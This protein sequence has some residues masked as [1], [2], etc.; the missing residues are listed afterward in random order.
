MAWPIRSLAEASSRI[1]GAFRQYMPGTDAALKNNTI[2]I[3]GKVLTVMVHEFEL[4]L[5]FLAKQLFLSTATGQWLVLHCRDIGIYRKPASAASG[6]AIG[7]AAPSTTYPA[8]VRLLSGNVS[9][10]STAAATSTSGGVLSLSVLSE[11]KGA[12]SNREEGGLLD[13]ADPILWPDLGT[14]W[15]VGAAGLGGGAD[16]EQDES[17][18]ERG[19]QRKRN[20]PGGGSLSDYERIVRAVPGVLRAW[21]FRVQNAPGMLVVHFLFEGRDNFIPTPADVAVVQAAVDA[22]RLIRVDNS[23]VTAPVARPIDVTINGLSGDSGEIRAAIATAIRA[24]FL[25]RC[26]PGI[27]GDTFSVSRSW[28][29]EAI[30]GVVGEDRHQLVNPTGD[31]L[32][33][34][35]QFPTLGTVTYGA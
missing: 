6:I 18:R 16:V 23:V 34:G 31:I 17:L 8:G 32:L 19:L 1:R 9:Y 27:A 12:L 24:M 28:I 25:E 29:A 21:A 15:V 13:L 26:R 33:T 2:T 35:G 14:E 5:A 11:V 10:I 20:P 7:T 3:I 22:Q 4:R 30:S